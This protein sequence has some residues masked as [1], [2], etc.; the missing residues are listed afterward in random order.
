M[1]CLYLNIAEIPTTENVILKN[2][3]IF[4]KIN[5]SIKRWN[6]EQ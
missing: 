6:T 1:E 3:Q 2:I 4:N 5:E